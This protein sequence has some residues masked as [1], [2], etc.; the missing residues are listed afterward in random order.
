MNRLSLV[1]SICVMVR[2]DRKNP[3]NPNLTSEELLH[4]KSWLKINSDLASQTNQILKGSK[5]E[6]KN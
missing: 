2:V 1:N 3:D 6:D 4:L 5:R